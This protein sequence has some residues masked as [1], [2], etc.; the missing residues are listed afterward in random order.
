[1]KEVSHRSHGWLLIC[2]AWPDPKLSA[3]GR[4]TH[5]VL[6]LLL[7]ADKN[8]VIASI[9][10]PTPYTRLLESQGVSCH[11][12]ALND[13]RFD[14]WIL[15]QQFEGAVLDRF[16]SFEQFAW[17]LKKVLPSCMLVLDLQDLHFVRVGRAQSFRKEDLSGQWQD[18][19]FPGEWS[20][21]LSSQKEQKLMLRELTCI[22]QADLTLVISRFEKQF[23]EDL[24]GSHARLFFLPFLSP[25][26]QALD[27]LEHRS[28]RRG[29][30]FLGN[31]RH[32]PNLD[33]AQVL[34]K[35]WPAIRQNV[36]NDAGLHMGGVFMPAV[37]SQAHLPEAKIFMEGMVAD[38]KQFLAKHRVL[39]APLRFGAGQKGK[40]LEAWEAGLPVVTTPI[41]LEGMV[42]T[43]GSELPDVAHSWEEFIA[44]TVALLNCEQTWKASQDRG[45]R[46]LKQF[47]SEAF[48]TPFF[49]AL[50]GFLDQRQSVF[51]KQNLVQK[52]LWQNHCLTHKYMS[53]W[54]ALK[55]DPAKSC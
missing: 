41:G 34:L 8:V 17:R 52:I 48:E 21:G 23:L 46:A 47:Q 55:S 14:D 11:S 27:V 45:F 26:P 16:V 6:R 22:L 18:L 4:R 3:A 12:I 43:R 38:A 39:C 2:Y 9:S 24:L 33:A 10:Q 42:E 13:S 31:F 32:L 37:L 44:Q 30:C 28:G 40:I 51:F 53:R 19:Q 29:V 25:Q 35:L 36:P 5:D 15:E 54:I 50:E 1:M 20:S 7:L 49:Q